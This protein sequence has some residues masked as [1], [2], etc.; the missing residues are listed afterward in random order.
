MM[1]LSEEAIQKLQQLQS[2]WF[3]IYWGFIPLM[4][5]LA[6]FGDEIFGLP[7]FRTGSLTWGLI[8]GS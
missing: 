5:Y 8:P 6:Y 3:A 7:G 1:K 2:A 4:C